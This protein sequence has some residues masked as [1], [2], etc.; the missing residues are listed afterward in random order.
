MLDARSS[1][2]H[3]RMRRGLSVSIVISVP[4]GTA[5]RPI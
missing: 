3:A 1:I 4:S 5:G 2:A